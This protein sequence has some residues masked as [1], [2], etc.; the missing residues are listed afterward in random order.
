MASTA[1]PA[2][3]ADLHRRRPVGDEFDLDRRPHRDRPSG[4]GIRSGPASGPP[5]LGALLEGAGFSVVPP[6]GRGPTTPDP[7]EPADPASGT[8]LRVRRERTLPDRV[9]PGLRLL[10]CGLNP[11]LHAADS[12]IPFGRPGNRFWPALLAAGL[13]TRDRDPD[14]A[15]TEHGIG[16]TD[17]A[18]R[19]T[20]TAAEL[21]PHELVAGAV[22]LERLVR[23]LRPG[24]V[25]FLGLA[26]YRLAVGPSAVAGPVA[27]FGGRPTLLAGNPSGLNAHWQHDDLVRALREAVVLGETHRGPGGPVAR[28]DG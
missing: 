16:F 27:A 23:W 8:V 3:L 11:S 26:G 13:A 22:R 28:P 17:L 21:A 19:A 25:C 24:A 6:T 7:A 4:R 1:I 5:G 12:G 9:R 15:L 2:A 20:R 10:V 14:E 18:K